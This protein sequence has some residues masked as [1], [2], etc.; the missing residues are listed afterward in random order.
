MR[1]L[2]TA[3]L[4]YLVMMAN[5]SAQTKKSLWTVQASDDGT[6]VASIAMDHPGASG[7]TI[8]SLMNVGFGPRG[9]CQPEVG[10]A[11]LKGDGYGKP[12]GKISPP[13]TEPVNLMVDQKPVLTQAPFLVKYDNG[14]E[15]VFP[16]SRQV[17]QALAA[18]ITASVQI[19]SGTPKFEF[20]IAGAADA[21]ADARKR[22]ISAIDAP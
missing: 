1:Y 15:V 21:I 3:A 7:T 5:V 6:I 8:V 13:H 17:L 14:L 10:I 11:M 16:A 4:A 20:P 22:C 19:V 12:V 2:L 9:G 18:G